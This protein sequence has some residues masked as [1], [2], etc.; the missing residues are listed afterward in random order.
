MADA[1]TNGESRW[2]NGAFIRVDQSSRVIDPASH[3]DTG[4]E[5]ESEPTISEITAKAYQLYKERAG[6]SG[7]FEDDWLRAE[8]ELTSDFGIT[9]V[10]DP[11]PASTPAQRAAIGSPVC[12]SFVQRMNRVLRVCDHRVKH[13]WELRTRKASS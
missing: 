13:I 2:S 9:P 1:I 8:Q 11:A 10:I 12:C 5:W 4:Y 6:Q 3:R 7:S